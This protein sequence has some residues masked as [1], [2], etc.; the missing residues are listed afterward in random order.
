MSVSVL[1]MHDRYANIE[2]AYL[3]E[4]IEGHEGV[5]I[6]ATNLRRNRTTERFFCP[7]N[8]S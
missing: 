3:L 7:R 4:T 8:A 6:L 1:A 5:V 2:V